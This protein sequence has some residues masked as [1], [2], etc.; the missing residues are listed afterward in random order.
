MIPRIHKQGS[1]TRG[2]LNYLYGKGTREEHVDP[3][4]VASFDDMAPDPGRDPSATKEDLQR[5]LDQPLH[6]LDV[7]Q[8]PDQHVWHCSVRAA[9]T[10]RILSDE[11]WG[12]IA[13]RIVAATGIDPAAQT[14]PGA[15]G[16]PSATP[17]TTSTSSPP[18]Y[19]RT[20]AAPTTTAPVSA[21]RPKPVSSKPT[22]AYTA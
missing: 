17:T 9:R 16:P 22:T 13:R 20:A 1:S 8:R 3:H 21:P 7:D 4:L 14:T 10:D 19:A 6:L 5:L 15:G 12:A 11:E 2:L 18:S